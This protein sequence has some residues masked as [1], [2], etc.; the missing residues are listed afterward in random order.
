MTSPTS[1]SRNERRLNVCLS[2][3]L[4]RQR[5]QRE[6][7]SEEAQCVDRQSCR[8][9]VSPLPLPISGVSE[10]VDA[11]G[12]GDLVD[13]DADS[14]PQ[15]VDGS[16]RHFAQCVFDLG[17]DLFD[18]VHVGAVGRQELLFRRGGLDGWADAGDLVRGEIVHDDEVA[19]LERRDED[20]FDI[21]AKFSPL[22]GPS[23]T[24]GAVTPSWRKAAMSVVVFQW[25]NGTYAMRRLPFS[26]RP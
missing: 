14:V 12:G 19:R 10:V 1:V 18:G 21:G 25:P 11:F 23:N 9:S 16:P 7:R 22:I 24:Q 4:A 17:E 5:S 26:Q 20:L 13:C 3:A 15:G 2:Y 8:R 6:A